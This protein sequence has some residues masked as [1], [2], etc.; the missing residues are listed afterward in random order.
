MDG[1][2]AKYLMGLV[3]PKAQQG[4]NWERG[5]SLDITQDREMSLPT[6]WVKQGLRKPQGT[7]VETI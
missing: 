5:L 6:L 4:P 1:D 7:V 3:G 2:A